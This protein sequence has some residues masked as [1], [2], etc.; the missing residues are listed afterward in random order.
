MIPLRYGAKLKELYIKTNRVVMFYRQIMVFIIKIK[1]SLIRAAYFETYRSH[2]L[3][4]IIR[5]YY[6]K[7]ILIILLALLSI[8]TMFIAV[9]ICT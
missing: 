1:P 2:S 9:G 7:G 5:L 3:V 4:K 8:K 6:F